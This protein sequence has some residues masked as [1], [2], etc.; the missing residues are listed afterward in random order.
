LNWFVRWNLFEAGP[1]TAEDAQ[2]S[3]LYRTD[4]AR[5]EL[6]SRFI[7]VDTY[8]RD[9][10]M[11]AEIRPLDAFSLPRVAQLIQRT[12]QFN[13][14]TRRHG[15]AALQAFQGGPRAACFSVRLTDRL[16]DNGIVAAVIGVARGEGL[17]I[18]TWVMSCRVFGRCLEHVTLAAVVERARGL[19]CRRVIGHYAPTAKNKVVADLY[20]RLGFVAEETR[21]DVSELAL[22]V[23]SFAPATVPIGVRHPVHEE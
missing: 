4:A 8:L 13:L 21:G 14:T 16:G 1:Q 18:D 15:E 23:A 17:V 20:P 6:R 2:R 10:E 3:A 9:L 5:A 11:E 7:D 12:N 19:G 22:D